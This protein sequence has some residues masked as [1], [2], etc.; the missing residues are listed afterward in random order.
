MHINIKILNYITNVPTCFGASASSSG[1]YYT[2][3]VKVIKL[4]KLH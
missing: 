3:F 2:A 1:S 4:L